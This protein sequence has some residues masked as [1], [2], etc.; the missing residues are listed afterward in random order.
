MSRL[1]WN[2]FE[3]ALLVFT[4][5]HTCA[6]DGFTAG[7]LS[8]ALLFRERDAARFIQEKTGSCRRGHCYSLA[9][10]T[11]IWWSK[12]LVRCEAPASNRYKTRLPLTLAPLLD[13]QL[14]TVSFVTE[15]HLIRGES[16]VDPSEDTRRATPVQDR[17]KAYALLA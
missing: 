16:G 9:R 7:C 15:T 6:L 8:Q 2:T 13:A 14:A 10:G 5:E 3:R 1:N 12:S 11:I 17:L 4:F